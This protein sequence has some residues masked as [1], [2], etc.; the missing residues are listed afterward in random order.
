MNIKTCVCVCVCGC[1]LCQIF[2][3]KY[4]IILTA[5]S[6]FILP[7]HSKSIVKNTEHA[8]H[9]LQYMTPCSLLWSLH[10]LPDFKNITET[11]KHV[12]RISQ[13]SSSVVLLPCCNDCRVKGH[14]M[15]HPMMMIPA[16]VQGIKYRLK[17]FIFLMEHFH[18]PAPFV[19]S[20][21]SASTP[22][23]PL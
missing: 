14:S 13:I 17:H 9:T 20:S 10:T 2:I 22:S 7:V 8:Y 3:L 6:I 19:Y 11:K 15:E 4:F 18:L 1:S 12:S 16:A 5:K 21:S 23:P